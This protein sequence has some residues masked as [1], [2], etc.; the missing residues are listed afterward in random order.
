MALPPVRARRLCLLAGLAAW[1][2][3]GAAYYAQHVLQMLP[4]PWCILQR[5]L[6]LLVGAGLLGLALLPDLRDGIPALGRRVLVVLTTAFALAGMAAALYQNRVAS[7]S[8]SCDL[9]LADRVISGLGLD[10]AFPELFEVR[11]SCAD[12]AVDLFGVPFELWSLALFVALAG[13]TLQRWNSL[14]TR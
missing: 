12:A 13:V 6:F 5:I 2:S 9:T 14:S 8:P 1:G 4:C 11:A 10:A 3:V 7:K